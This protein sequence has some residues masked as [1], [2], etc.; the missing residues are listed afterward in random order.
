MRV[1]AVADLQDIECIN[2]RQISVSSLTYAWE[3]V[4]ISAL[5][6]GGEGV[7]KA[8]AEAVLERYDETEEVYHRFVATTS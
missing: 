2:M 5:D 4:S 3:G 6:H 7:A 1:D 8:L